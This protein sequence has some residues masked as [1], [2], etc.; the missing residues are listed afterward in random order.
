MGS[1]ERTICIVAVMTP[2]SLSVFILNLLWN[3]CTLDE[4]PSIISELVE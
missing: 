1:V 4:S 2:F 3:S